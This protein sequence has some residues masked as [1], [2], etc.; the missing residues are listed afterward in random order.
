M[1]M[2]FK[3]RRLGPLLTVAVVSCVVDQSTT[4]D[5][6]LGRATQAV[7]S[8]SFNVQVTLPSGVFLGDAPV[9]AA[10]ALNLG[11]RDT[12]GGEVVSA[13]GDVALGNDGHAGSVVSGGNV[14]LRDRAHVTGNI[15][16][17]GSVTPGN[18][19][20]IQGTVS[21]HA[22]VP[23]TTVSWTATEP[24]TSLGSVTL[25]PGGV[26]A[27]SPGVYDALTANS[28]SSVFLQSGTYF[29]SSIDIEPQATLFVDSSQGPVIVYVTSSVI[30]RGSVQAVD[31]GLPRLFVGYLGT[32]P[33]TVSAPFT[34]VFFAPSADLSLQ[35]GNGI[36]NLATLYGKTLTVQPDAVV[37][38]FPFDFTVFGVPSNPSNNAPRPTVFLTKPAA[39][40]T[41]NLPGDAAGNATSSA[42]PSSPTT[43]TLPPSFPVA[44]GAIA[45]GTVTVTF[46]P[47]GGALV[48]CTYRGGS[49]TALPTT[50]ADFELGRILTFVSCSD[51]RPAGVPRT[52]SNF[53]LTVNRT[54]TLPV[55]V[56]LPLDDNACGHEF[57]ILSPVDTLNMHDSFHWSAHQKPVAEKNPDTTPALYYAWMYVKNRDELLQVKKLYVHI[58][59]RP[60]FTEELSQFGGTCGTFRNPGDGRGVFVPVVL[61]GLVY[62]EILAIQTSNAVNGNRFPFDAVIIRPVPAGAA[63]PNGSIS[64]AALRRANFHYLGAQPGQPLPAQAN[65]TLDGGVSQAL[66]AAFTFLADAVKTIGRDVTNAIGAID[67]FLQG[68]VTMDLR[69][70][71]LNLNPE[72]NDTEPMTRGWGSNQGSPIGV[73]G[74]TVT[75]MENVLD[76]I[77]STFISTT[78]GDGR[79][80]ID[81][82]KNSARGSGICVEFDNGAARISDF[83]T[84]NEICDLRGFA[85]TANAPPPSSLGGVQLDFST[86][87][88]LDIGVA[89]GDMNA[90]YQADDVH[91]Y[92]INVAGHTTKRARVLTGYWAN[93][94]SKSS[95]D[96][97]RKLPFTPCLNFNNTLSDA[98]VG[99]AAL[100]DFLVSLAIPAAIFAEP[101]VI[102][103]A[104]ILANSDIIMPS[105]SSIQNSREVG[106]HEYGH[107][108]FCSMMQEVNGNAVDNL[109]FDTIFNAGAD[110]SAPVRYINEGWADFISGQVA[111]TANYGWLLNSV[112]DGKTCTA[113]IP[114]CYDQNRTGSD[115]TGSNDFGHQQ[116]ARISTLIH[117]VFDGH[118]ERT[119][120]ANASLPNAP[121]D[122]D[123]WTRASGS[124]DYSPVGYGDQ[125]DEH[126]A[127]A[128]SAIRAFVRHIGEGLGPL[129]TGP[130]VD[131]N[132][133]YGALNQT[134]VENGV[135]YC[136]R[137]QVFALHSSMG[138]NPP[139]TISDQ[140]SAC[141]TD[142][143]IAA[144][145]GPAQPSTCGVTCPADAV[146]DGNKAALGLFDFDITVQAAND[147]CPDV[148]VLEVDNPQSFFT[149]DNAAG[150]STA[151]RAPPNQATCQTSFAL[152]FSE[153]QGGSAFVTQ[154]VQTQTGVFTTCA[155]GAPLC[156]QFCNN[157]PTVQFNASNVPTA[158]LQFRT[159]TV[160][161]RHLQFNAA[162]IIVIK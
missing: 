106:S 92:L 99:G 108:S 156:I 132:K 109:I 45:N 146:V 71:A 80:V 35:P 23:S 119:G 6:S 126:V 72:F 136:D 105:N 133:V 129:G 159:P 1:T 51:G 15:V 91:Q 24:S 27:P 2:K 153:Q 37:Q 41:S 88:Q 128:G 93:T 94:F 154:S 43:F 30:Y 96:G 107:Y 32:N 26:G 110:T 21:S 120:A 122:A 150:I 67:A 8:S 25:Q 3:V 124:V 7:T 138:A 69:I 143:R 144:A 125:A 28:R 102:V 10:G 148:F 116:I 57:D 84:S 40:P 14:T 134:M 160:A 16:A 52:G 19:D 83:L 77:P 123:A 157:L 162:P 13:H 79:V 55:T 97:T 104:S 53:T 70:R 42:N 135:G 89:D 145:L 59:S 98:I 100:A 127:L 65:I 61:P 151:F 118:G 9:S 56:T 34:G 139:T 74:L 141:L 39:S 54:S 62:N 66:T 158:N 147:I 82:A 85:V 117:D 12:I 4:P 121:S 86:N 112:L 31:S 44:A 68:S 50:N 81:A 47:P 78:G 48:T 46:N 90:M 33:V 114:N 111:S 140:L 5:E 38:P 49:S 22:A 95:K 11:D 103:A 58:L 137:C 60:L 113:D 155:P 101:V 29:F 36:T 161:G 75:L 142:G 152:T 20:V 131:D 17:A 115:T 64:Y 73:G 18:S 130:T 149:R 63:N 76:F 87:Q